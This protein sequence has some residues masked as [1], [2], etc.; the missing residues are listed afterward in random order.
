MTCATEHL[1]GKTVG[2]GENHGFM[3]ETEKV[4]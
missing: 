3:Y 4:K 2:V 1:T